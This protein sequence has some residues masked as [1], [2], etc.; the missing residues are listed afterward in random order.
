MN[1]QEISKTKQFQELLKQIPEQEREKVEEAIKAM[2]EDFNKN[3]IIPLGS[4]A[5]R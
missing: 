3:V 1:Y 2:V 4:L 5:K